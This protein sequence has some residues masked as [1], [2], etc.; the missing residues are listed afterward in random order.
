M[1][2]PLQKYFLAHLA[3][4]H[5]AIWEGYEINPFI[6]KLHWLWHF[7]PAIEILTKTDSKRIN[8]F[9]LV[10]KFKSFEK[11]SISLEMT[12]GQGNHPLNYRA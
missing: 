2:C 12:R 4:A 1:K 11:E 5:G 8:V 9:C 10:L 3:P 6:A 7:I